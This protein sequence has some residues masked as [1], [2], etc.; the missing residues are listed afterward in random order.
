MRWKYLTA[1]ND[2]HLPVHTG[3]PGDTHELLLIFKD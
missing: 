1:T 2:S 3:W